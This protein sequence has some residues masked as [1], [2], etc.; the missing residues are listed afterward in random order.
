MAAYG[1][2]AMMGGIP[3]LA[4]AEFVRDL[5]SAEVPVAGR[6]QAALDAA[7]RDAM[8]Q[9]LVKLSGSEEVLAFPEVKTA[10]SRSRGYVQQYAYR[11]GQGDTPLTASFEFDG[12]VMTRIITD[13]GAPLWT[14]NRPLVLVWLV[15]EDGSGRYFVNQESAPELADELLKAFNRRGVPVQLPLFDLAV[16]LALSSLVLFVIEIEKWLIRR[17]VIYRGS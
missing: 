6:Q 9:V 12:N 1:A 4:E 5:Y 16:C 3:G 10:L 7:S 15:V 17:G 11:G 2:C 13:A 8:A 14:A